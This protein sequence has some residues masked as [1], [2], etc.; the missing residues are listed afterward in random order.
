MN[1]FSFF[2]V[3]LKNKGCALFFF[4]VFV[5]LLLLGKVELKGECK[6]EGEKSDNRKTSMERKKKKSE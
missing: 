4:S 1:I 3:K 6:R 5:F 2:P